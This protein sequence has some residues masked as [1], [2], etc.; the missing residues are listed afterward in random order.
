MKT[1][2]VE[3]PKPITPATRRHRIVLE[4]AKLDGNAL[5]ISSNTPLIPIEDCNSVVAEMTAALKG[6]LADF[7]NDLAE[8]I[9]GGFPSA[10]PD[11]PDA[12]LRSIVIALQECPADLHREIY[13]A[14]TLRR[15]SSFP[16]V[17]GEV[18]AAIMF[19]TRQRRAAMAVAQAH[20]KEHEARASGKE[21]LPW[22][23]WSPERKQAHNDMMT[24]YY[25]AAGV[26]YKPMP[27]YP[28]E[29]M[30]ETRKDDIREE[31]QEKVA[32]S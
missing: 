27:I 1:E 30:S 9:L 3:I 6:M 13:K 32:E 16:P 21:K 31:R 12:Y 18:T 15:D 2:L 22:S 4:A 11:N 7:A 25:A 20:L 14:V 26:V 19:L 5:A 29:K 8:D 17:A 10:R 23:Q 24:K 28:E